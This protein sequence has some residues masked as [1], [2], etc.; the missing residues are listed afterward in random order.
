MTDRFDPGYDGVPLAPFNDKHVGSLIPSVQQS[1]LTAPWATTFHHPCT[2]FF[3]RLSPSPLIIWPEYWSL[4]LSIFADKVGLSSPTMIRTNAL[5]LCSFH[6][7]LSILLQH[8]ISQN[9]WSCSCSHSPHFRPIGGYWG[10]ESVML[11]V[12]INPNYTS[13]QLS[14]LSSL[15]H[16]SGCECRC[17][18]TEESR[19]QS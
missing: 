2:M 17:R 6:D 15:K 19:D 1:F 13:N 7:T 14:L 18:E 3:S 16:V 10:D 5:V 8:Y 9:R 11:D 4:F 12:Y